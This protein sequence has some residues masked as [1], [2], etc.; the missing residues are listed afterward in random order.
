MPSSA[1]VLREAFARLRAPVSILMGDRG[2]VRACGVELRRSLEFKTAVQRAGT[3]SSKGR[4]AG[5]A[6]PA[7]EQTLCRQSAVALPRDPDAQSVALH[8]SSFR[9]FRRGPSPEILVRSGTAT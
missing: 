3:T 7:H 4:H 5:G 2:G 8:A 9:G 1:R 6:V